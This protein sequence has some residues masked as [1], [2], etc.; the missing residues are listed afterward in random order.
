MVSKTEDIAFVA[1]CQRAKCIS[2]EVESALHDVG[3]ELNNKVVTCC[4]WTKSSTKSTRDGV[5]AQLSN[6]VG[7]N[8]ADGIGDSGWSDGCRGW[9]N[10]KADRFI[11][12]AFNTSIVE[13][14]V[15]NSQSTIVG[16][17]RSKCL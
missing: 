10:D 4:D 1:C 8:L 2:I 9:S 17:A 16:D 12:E 6:K 15:A 14:C 5:V 13:V 7:A 11:D 3:R